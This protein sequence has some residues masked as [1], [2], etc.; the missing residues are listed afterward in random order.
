MLRRGR[1]D[2]SFVQNG[3]EIREITSFRGAISGRSLSHWLNRL[4]FDYLIQMNPFA[5]LGI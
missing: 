5:F 2:S 4:S 3:R 1:V